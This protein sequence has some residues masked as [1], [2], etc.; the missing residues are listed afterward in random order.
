MIDT[1]RWEAL[2]DALLAELTLLEELRTLTL[3]AAQPLGNLDVAG[4]EAW[5]R[6]QGELLARLGQAS[7]ARAASQDSCLP[8]RARGVSGSGP[9]AANVTMQNLI[10]RA[11]MHI[12]DRLRTFR[13][14]LRQLRDDIALASARNEILIRHVLEFTDHF[15]EGLTSPDGAPAAYDAR[16]QTA[17]GARGT[18]DLFNSAL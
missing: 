6:T 17:T 16:G 7:R 15:G 11:P 13:D 18:G 3:A 8:A 9:L 2:L 14:G 12:G 5:V 1:N 10:V 4:V